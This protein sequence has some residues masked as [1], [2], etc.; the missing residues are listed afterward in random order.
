MTDLADRAQAEMEALEN[1]RKMHRT[2]V[3]KVGVTNVPRDCVDC[4]EAIPQAR[5]NAV[6]HCVRCVDCQELSER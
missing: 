5:I 3:P 2:S 4:G 6:P 1:L